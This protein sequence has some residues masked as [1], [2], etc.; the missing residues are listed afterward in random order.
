MALDS[1]AYWLQFTLLS[2]LG[3]LFSTFTHEDLDEKY[4]HVAS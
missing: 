4:S 3:S 2:R 1:T